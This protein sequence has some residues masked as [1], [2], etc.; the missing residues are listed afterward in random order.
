MVAVNHMNHDVA[1]VN[2]SDPPML[3]GSFLYEKE[4]GYKA[5]GLEV[6]D[7]IVGLTVEY[8][9]IFIYPK[10]NALIRVY[11]I[12]AYITVTSFPG[13]Q[14]QL[15]VEGLVKLHRMM[16]GRHF[17][18]VS[19]SYS[20]CLRSSCVTKACMSPTVSRSSVL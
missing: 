20:T 12:N 10:P 15:T 5:R 1:E 17:I 9:G 8:V 11:F 4:P 16:S 13:V 19:T 7:L 6:W 18:H 3:P 14:S 2:G